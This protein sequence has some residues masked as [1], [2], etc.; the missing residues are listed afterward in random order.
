MG[1]SP[2]NSN[3]LKGQIMPKF[4]GLVKLTAHKGYVEV[5]RADAVAGGVEYNADDANEIAKMAVTHADKLKFKVKA[6]IPN[7]EPSETGSKGE[8]LF[9]TAKLKK[10]ALEPMVLKARSR[11]LPYL[12]FLEPRPAATAKAQGLGDAKASK[13]KEPEVPQ[14]L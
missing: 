13:P 1:S 6:F 2:F 10:L 9:T 5:V 11:P 12:A 7:V 3:V 14:G 4:N 8:T